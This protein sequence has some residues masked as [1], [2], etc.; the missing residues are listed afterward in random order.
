[1]IFQGIAVL[2][3]NTNLASM[4]VGL[5]RSSVFL[6]AFLPFILQQGG[7]KNQEPDSCELQRGEAVRGHLQDQQDHQAGH[8][9]H[10]HQVLLQKSGHQ[11][12]T[13]CSGR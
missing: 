12:Q 6:G 13:S 4:A 10:P 9:R 2:C 7:R 11:T 8:Q 1:M 5:R 3:E